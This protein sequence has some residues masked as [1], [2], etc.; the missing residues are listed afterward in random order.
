MA[1][2]KDVTALAN[3]YLVEY[4]NNL[5]FFGYTGGVPRPGGAL[6]QIDSQALLTFDN[7]TTRGAYN[8]NDMLTVCNGGQSEAEYRA[9]FSVW[10][11]LTSPL[12][13]GNDVRNL[14]ASCAAIVL[15]KDVIAIQQDANVVRGTLVQQWPDAHWPAP[16]AVARS[17]SRAGAAGAAPTMLGTV[18]FEPCA[19]SASSRWRWL[20]K[21]THHMLALD[22]QD[23][24]LTYGG[25]REANLGLASC[26]GWDEPTVGGQTWELAR[27]PEGGTILRT[28]AADGG[29]GKCLAPKLEPSPTRN[30]GEGLCNAS[31]G[32][33]MEVCD[34]G[35]QAD[36]GYQR[37]C[38][39]AMEFLVRPVAAAAAGEP[40]AVQ[41]ASKLEPALCLSAG[42]MPHSSMNIT[43]QIWAKPL[44][45]GEVA[46]LAF[47][48]GEFATE[49]EFQWEALKLPGGS[50][51]K[52][53]VRDVWSKA[54][55]GSFV[56]GFA[57]T[58]QPHDVAMVVLKPTAS[59]Y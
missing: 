22:G 33:P 11:I 1:E 10:A 23:R 28:T 13:L 49:A 41:L 26:V 50:A 24:C 16:G 6:S 32:V 45:S 4:C 18:V 54:S 25:Y 46:A 53:A 58:V 38:P 47:N 37:H 35:D 12:I 29:V 5:D 55:L 44:A 19:S 39:A 43:L 40:G 7:L 56:Q 17:S 31:A 14:S 30:P 34:C 8:D 9:Q 3:S 36:C 21:S 20:N 59:R 2:G 48:R 15:N 51:S 57:A 42:A 52:W 27:G